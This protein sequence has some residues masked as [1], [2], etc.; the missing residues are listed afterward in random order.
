MALPRR[1][2]RGAGADQGCAV[3]DG[4][5]AHDGSGQGHPRVEGAGPGPGAA[6]LRSLSA[7]RTEA[8]RSNE[9]HRVSCTGGAFTRVTYGRKDYVGSAQKGWSAP[10]QR[11]GPCT[12]PLVR[13][14]TCHPTCPT[15]QPEYP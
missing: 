9:R 3:I 13:D 7:S 15:S 14:G 2:D 6:H 1:T 8:E 10:F 5:G 4:A 11:G 12:P